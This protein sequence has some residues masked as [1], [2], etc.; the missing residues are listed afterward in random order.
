[1]DK[2]IQA[3]LGYV[4][5][6]TIAALR[7]LGDTRVEVTEVI[8]ASLG[9]NANTNLQTRMQIASVQSAWD[10]ARVFVERKAVLEAE[11]KLQGEPRTIKISEFERTQAAHENS[12]ERSTNS[13]SLRLC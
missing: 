5:F 7:G 4:G 1:M 3:K 13:R 9:I 2:Q 11:E 6:K 12:T 10:S 8:S